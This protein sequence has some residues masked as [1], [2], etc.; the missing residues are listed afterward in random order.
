MWFSNKTSTTTQTLQ[1]CYCKRTQAS[2]MILFETG[3]FS[4]S[5]ASKLTQAFDQFKTIM[6]HSNK[7]CVVQASPKDQNVASV[8]YKLL[9]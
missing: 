7:E 3:F 9:V 4:M 8:T 5:L 1:D 2:K 6:Q